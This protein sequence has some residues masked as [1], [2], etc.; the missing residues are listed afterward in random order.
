MSAATALAE[1]CAPDP[2]EDRARARDQRTAEHEAMLRRLA[3]IGMAMA[4]ALADEMA[5]VRA[6][7]PDDQGVRPS[8][9]PLSLAYNRVARAVRQTLAMEVHVTAGENRRLA[10][11]EAVRAKAA[12]EI[13]ER[14]SR[15]ETGRLIKAMVAHDIL[16]ELIEA[17]HKDD[18]ETWAR[19]HARAYEQ[20][21]D[22]K[23]DED[24]PDR[25]MGELIA[26]VAKAI[27]LCPDWDRWAGEDWAEEDAEDRPWGSPYGRGFK[28]WTREDVAGGVGETGPP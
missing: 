25:S 1:P 10:D 9:A 15:A 13:A 27:G 7:T 26:T 6:A 23:D 22:A 14:E 11:I 2:S 20:P 18:D 4:E 16:G 21:V 19:L 24:F 8:V 12:A 3:E 28:P 5:E 17:E